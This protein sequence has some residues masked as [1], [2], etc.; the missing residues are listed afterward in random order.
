M[1]IIKE[2]I[3]K[4]QMSIFHPLL[5]GKLRHLCELLNLF[6]LDSNFQHQFSNLP[7]AMF[8]FQSSSTPTNCPS[9]LEISHNWVSSKT[10]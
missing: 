3:K 5:P 1:I 2:L 4:H 6:N 8:Q 9:F 7:K 10:T